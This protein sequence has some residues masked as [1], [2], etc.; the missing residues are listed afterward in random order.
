VN[1]AGG[2]TEMLELINWL[3]AKESGTAAH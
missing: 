1:S 3:V 2:V